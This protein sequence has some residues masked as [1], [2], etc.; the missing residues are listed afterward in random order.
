MFILMIFFVFIVY[1]KKIVNN[2]FKKNML[3]IILYYTVLKTHI[4]T[5]M[6]HRMSLR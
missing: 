6:I 3:K 2:I 5:L 4:V 1:T